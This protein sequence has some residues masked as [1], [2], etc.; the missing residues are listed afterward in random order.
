MR[1]GRFGLVGAADWVACDLSLKRRVLLTRL[2]YAP[3]FGAPEG[4]EPPTLRLKGGGSD[5]AE[6]RAHW[7]KLEGAAG[8]EPAFS[9]RLRCPV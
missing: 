8:F 9:V 7:G 6:L 3:V 4:F 1:G 5:Q 2:S